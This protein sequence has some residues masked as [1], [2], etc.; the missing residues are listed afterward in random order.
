MHKRFYSLVGLLLMTVLLLILPTL[1]LGED[2][3]SLETPASFFSWETIGTFSGAVAT[4]VFV[5]Q[6]L[7]LPLDKVKHIPTQYVVYA[8]SLLVL[9]LAQAF[10]P[11]L[12]GLTWERGI[13]CVFNAILVCLTAM[14]VYTVM[15]QTPE[16]EKML[17]QGIDEGIGQIVAGIGEAIEVEVNGVK[18]ATDSHGYASTSVNPNA[19]SGGSLNALST[20]SASAVTAANT[21]SHS[22]SGSIG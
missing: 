15:I 9:L 8:M 19:A 12:G 7:K 3:L 2:L 22:V 4:V 13:L 1:A 21:S 20:D 18:V 11:G 6:L 17:A 5:V 14:S 10:V 16:T